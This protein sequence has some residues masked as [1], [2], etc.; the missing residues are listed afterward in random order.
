[1]P[2][3]APSGTSTK[4]RNSCHSCAVSKVKCPKEKPT[5]SKCESRG[6]P[7]QYFLARRPGRRVDRSK[8]L[9][10]GNDNSLGID[11]AFGPDPVTGLPGNFNAI[12]IEQTS[13]LACFLPET[14]TPPHN[15]S[16]RASYLDSSLGLE[17]SASPSRD[18]GFINT[19]P[20]VFSML[21][22]PGAIHSL[23]EF[24]HTTTDLDPAMSAMDYPFDMPVLSGADMTHPQSDISSLLLPPNILTPDLLPSDASPILDSLS[25]SSGGDGSLGSQS[26]S[27]SN[28]NSTMPH[29]AGYSTNCGCLA[30]ALE[31]LNSAS[32]TVSP[33]LTAHQGPEAS[34]ASIQTIINENRSSIAIVSNRLACAS[35]AGDN[36]LLAILFMIVL[37]ILERYASA[38]L[39]QPPWARG[40][41]SSTPRRSLKVRSNSIPILSDQRKQSVNHLQ[42]SMLEGVNKHVASQLV[43]SELFRVQLLIDQ[44]SMRLGT[45][46]D[47]SVRVMDMEF[48]IWSEHQMVGDSPDATMAAFSSNTLVQMERDV[49]Q[50]L[51]LLSAE[52][53][54]CLQKN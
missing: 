19:S 5:C 9:R 41:S 15:L 25:P 54:D 49:R 46:A 21:E 18:H 38:A 32:T 29:P 8:S 30:Q 27:A 50:S 24:E 51:N 17:F 6:I 7:C 33:C 42:P 20:D 48:C 36:S 40:L 4:L 26:R 43:L 3:N 23:S 44:L 28:R 31:L 13:P 12:S 2:R 39:A 22:G 11:T 34:M 53:I 16:R 52:I 37:R 35:C 14:T 45:P 1:M 47:G 10:L